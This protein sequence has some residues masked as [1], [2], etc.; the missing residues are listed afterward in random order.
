M[1]NVTPRRR[2]EI[3]RS[4]RSRDTEPELTLRRYLHRKGYRYRTN[5]ETLPGKP[6][7]V[8]SRMKKAV[9]VHGCFWHGH[10]N[11]SKARIPK[12]NCVFW[13]QKIERNKK[14][15]ERNSR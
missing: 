7:V 14:R 5:V 1:D 3:M 9:F 15:D 13:S 12:N 11:C 2:S 8:F 10:E 4:V 6:D